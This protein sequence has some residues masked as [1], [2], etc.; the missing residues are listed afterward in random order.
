MSFTEWLGDK[1]ESYSRSQ[2]YYVATSRLRARHA[3]A[4]KY[5]RAREK[6]AG[7]KLQVPHLPE[8]FHED[9]VLPNS[10]MLLDEWDEGFSVEDFL[11]ER[12]GAI[13]DYVHPRTGSKASS[14]ITTA[15]RNHNIDPKL[16][17]VSLQREKGIIRRPQLPEKVMDWACGV[18]A[19]DSGT[20][21]EK[22]R[23]FDHQIDK[24]AETYKN[25]F[26]GFHQ[27]EEIKVDFD[28]KTLVPINAATYAL[29]VYTPHVSAALLTWKVWKGFFGV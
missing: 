23:G 18:G 21:A 3:E 19:W 2:A 29:Y 22:Y 9:L 25:R 4:D 28:K 16:L 17:I 11:Q 26:A 12:G 14:L 7:K 6:S 10:F 13:K 20:W 1:I 8:P 27:G 15:A 24:A 5:L